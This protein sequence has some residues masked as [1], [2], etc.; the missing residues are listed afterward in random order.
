MKK[1]ALHWKILLGLLAGV[2]W[3]LLSI[4]FGLNTFT[5]HWIKPWG[6]IFLKLL[7]LI[8]I[9]LV[10][11]SIIT[12]VAGLADIKK[13]GRMGGKTIFIYLL[14]T[15]VAISIGLLVVNMLKPGNAIP[16]EQRVKN[17]IAYENWR[18]NTPGVL[19]VD[20]R[21]ISLDPAYQSFKSEDLPGATDDEAQKEERQKELNERLKAA[22]EAKERGPLSFLVDMVPDNIVNSL[23]SSSLLLQVIFFSLFFGVAIKKIPQTYSEKLVFFF[24]G[25]NHVYLIMI[26]MV[27]KAAPFFVFALMASNMVK[28]AGDDVSHLLSL[29]SVLMK[30]GLVVL[31]GLAIL[32]FLIY[33][34]VYA[35]LGY[36]EDESKSILGR[37]K[38]YFSAMGPAQLLAFS[39]SSSA[40]TLPLTIESVQKGLKV[41]KETTSFVLPIGATIN[42]DGT[43][44]YQAVAVV[45]LAQ[46][47]W[48]D[49]SLAQQLTIV[50]TASLA[51]IGSAAV[52]SAGLIMLIM[53][54]QSVNLNPAWF[55]IV[56]PIDRILDMCRT[57]INISGDGLVASLVERWE[58]KVERSKKI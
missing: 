45:F 20:D 8:A 41:S 48:I 56:V 47:H 58:Q 52:P 11:F 4:S 28:M 23:S 27:M 3:A 39:T 55:A 32:L 18:D 14:T 10:M 51:S 22:K 37:Y 19:P 1:M 5:T 12:G 21:K 43:S 36:R 38:H 16:E 46:L 26:D 49:L 9:P 30:Y 44:L 33:P 40:A 50:L 42:M 13:L 34:T 2:L 7:T 29:L 54:L 17:R 31:L 6:D 57:V 24:G 25:L 53:V 35:F 15:V